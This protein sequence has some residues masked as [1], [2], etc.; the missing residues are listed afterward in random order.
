MI[1]QYWGM[2]TT[3]F[4]VCS[5]TFMMAMYAME[6]RH[7]LFIAGFAFGCISTSVYG[8]LSGAWPFG[9]VEVVWAGIAFRRFGESHRRL[10]ASS[11]ITK[12]DIA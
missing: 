9:V 7:R 1:A 10:R 4:G 11:A 12:E 5:L 8:F 6:R 2:A 3:I